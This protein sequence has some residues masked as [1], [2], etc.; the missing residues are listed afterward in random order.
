MGFQFG[1]PQEIFRLIA[2]LNFSSIKSL[3]FF[4][5]GHK[6]VGI[7]FFLSLIVCTFFRSPQNLSVNN[8]S[9]SCLASLIVFFP[10]HVGFK[11]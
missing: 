11:R 2:R 3:F 5:R 10:K 1:T 9:R 6:R 8:D 4:Q 7:G